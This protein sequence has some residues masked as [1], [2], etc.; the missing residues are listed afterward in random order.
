[1]RATTVDA[2]VGRFHEGRVQYMQIA[3]NTERRAL[4]MRATTVDADERTTQC[5]VGGAL[6]GEVVNESHRNTRHASMVCRPSASC[7][8]GADADDCRTAAGTY[9]SSTGRRNGCVGEGVH[10]GRVKY[11]FEAA[12]WQE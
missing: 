2:N 4:F 8:R 12:T 11:T 7:G 10:E 5:C 9:D 6:V 3:R 1:M